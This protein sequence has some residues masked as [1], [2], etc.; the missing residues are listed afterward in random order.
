MQKNRKTLSRRRFLRGAGGALA[1][2][3]IASPDILGGNRTAPNDKLNIAYIGVAGRGGAQLSGL[4][5]GNNA[6]ALCDV[7]LRRAG[8]AFKRFPDAKRYRDFRRMF[9]AMEKSIDV[10]AVS[11]PDHTHAVAALAAMR[12]GKHVYCE[13][14]LA[15]SV[16]E[17]RAMMKA[18]RETGVVSQLGNQ[19]HSS[20]DIRKLVEWVRDGA[21]GKVHTVH[22]ACSAVHSR[23]K[24]L[25]RRSKKTDMSNVASTLPGPLF[26]NCFSV[27]L[28]IRMMRGWF[29]SAWRN[30]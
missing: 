7:D 20:G 4:S 29:S 8:G 17:V 22:A 13:K 19:G 25:P 12:R 6:V 9:D 3:T 1:A 15:H 5:G 24:E 27:M 23:I 30:E 2:F 14:P 28:R 16:S 21:I 26:F 18:A 10:V 11:T